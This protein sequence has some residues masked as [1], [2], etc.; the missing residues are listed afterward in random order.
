[1]V[2]S[3]SYA[4]FIRQGTVPCLVTI[5]G[6]FVNADDIKRYRGCSASLKDFTLETVSGFIVA[7]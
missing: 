7:H 2:D 1:M 6:I 4:T 3:I 5:I